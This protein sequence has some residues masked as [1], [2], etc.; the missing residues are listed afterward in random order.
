LGNFDED[1]WAVGLVSTQNL[2]R[3]NAVSLARDRVFAAINDLGLGLA[4]A[5][6]HCCCLLHGLE[7]T[8]KNALVSAVW[9]SCVAD[10][11]PTASSAL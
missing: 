10:R 7:V 5:A 8:E 11:P 9:Q 3:S 4:D 2:A 1:E 6:I